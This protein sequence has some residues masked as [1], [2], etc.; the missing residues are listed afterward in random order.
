[1]HQLAHDGLGLH[2]YSVVFRPV[3]FSV[4]VIETEKR[5]GRNKR[6]DPP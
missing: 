6:Q 4:F 5:L 1:M 3:A 2:F